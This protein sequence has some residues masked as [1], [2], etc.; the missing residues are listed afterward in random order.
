[1]TGR[2]GCMDKKPQMSGIPP[3]WSSPT[4]FPSTAT[5]S[6]SPGVGGRFSTCTGTTRC[7]WVTATC[8]S[9]MRTW[10]IIRPPPT[11]P[12]FSAGLRGP[13]CMTTH[14]GGASTRMHQEL[15]YRPKRL[16]HAKIVGWEFVRRRRVG[17]GWELGFW[18]F[19]GWLLLAVLNCGDA[20]PAP[21]S[22]ANEV[23][24]DR[25]SIDLSGQWEFKLDPLD[26]GRAEKWF[27]SRVSFE[28]MI[29]VPGAWNAQGV[30][31]DSEKQL[32]DYE[33]QRLEEQKPL[34]KLGTLGVQRE[35]ERLFSA[36]PGPGW[37]RKEVT[38]PADWRGEVPWLIL[39]GGH[40]E[41]EV[42]VNGQPA[43]AHR[44]YLTPFRLDLS[45]HGKAG[46]TI[47]IAVRVDARHRKEVD[48]LMG[49]LD[50]L[51]FLYITWGGLHGRVRLE[52]TEAT[53][54]DDVFIVPQLGAGTA[55]IRLT[56]GGARISPLA[57]VA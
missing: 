54:M 35:S 44:S 17:R 20:E 28:R 52:A 55:E 46:K 12:T 47:S 38:I 7:A 5:S 19:R 37:Y 3:G 2:K 50:T 14:D 18:C 30:A 48:P 9:S 6:L 21:R 42:W 56:L 49:C 34:N 51:D 4:I 57:A 43:G 25:P 32:R 45:Q 29:R 1:M 27:E 13:S 53:R 8:F 15:S 16:V 31:F 11:S 39:A 41:A 26:V 36:Y 33:S 40:R 24:T 10:V 22:T 23:R